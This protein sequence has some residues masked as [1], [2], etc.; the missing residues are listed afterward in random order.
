M[1]LSV[2]KIKDIVS[3]VKKELGVKLYAPVRYFQGLAA[4][5][6]IKKRMLTMIAYIRASKKNQ[7]M[8]KFVKPFETDRGMKT[9]TSS[10]TKKFYEKYGKKT[11]ELK[12]KHPDW[13]HFKVVSKA[14]GLKRSALKKSYD[15]GVAA[16][17]TGHRPGATADQWGFARMYSL[18]IRHK[19]KSLTHDTD[20]AKKLDVK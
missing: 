5:A 6:Q 11:R 9:K 2:K 4:K 7:T 3:D 18:I 12:K 8:K 16:Y 19:R 17:K 20:L 15:R 1:A 14:T 10:W 13:N